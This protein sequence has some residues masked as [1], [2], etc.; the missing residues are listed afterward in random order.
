MTVQN[1][2]HECNIRLNLWKSKG[3]GGGNIVTGGTSSGCIE[4][5]RCGVVWYGVCVCVCVVC[6]KN[7]IKIRIKCT[8]LKYIQCWGWRGSSGAR[9]TGFSCRGPGFGSSHLHDKLQPTITRVPGDMMF[10]SGLCGDQA[11]TWCTGIHAGETL[12]HLKITLKI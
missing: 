2:N 3:H 7:N 4:V 5:E 11:H 10:S 9:A 8:F 6:E 1:W 12:I